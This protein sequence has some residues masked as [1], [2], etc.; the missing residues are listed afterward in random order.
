MHDI[1]N[2]VIAFPALLH[3]C[4]QF[5]LS[6]SSGCTARS[7]DYLKLGQTLSSLPPLPLVLLAPKLQPDFGIL[8]LCTSSH[9][10][11]W[12]CEIQGLLQLMCRLAALGQIEDITIAPE[13]QPLACL[14]SNCMHEPSVWNKEKLIRNLLSPADSARRMAKYIW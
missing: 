7:P 3:A 13:S 1:E 11:A 9:S 2:A 5:Q 6:S 14:L 12:S 8:S 10:N 4:T